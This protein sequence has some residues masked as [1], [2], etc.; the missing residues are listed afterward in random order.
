[1]K[2][3]GRKILFLIATVFA[4][5]PFSV[6]YAASGTPLGNQNG[7]AVLGFEIYNCTNYVES[8]GSEEDGLYACQQAYVEETIPPS[9]RI[10]NDGTIDKDKYIMVVLT[11][12]S[13]IDSYI[14]FLN[15][16]VS[17]NDEQLTAISLYDTAMYYEDTDYPYKK[18][19][20]NYVSRFTIDSANPEV[21]AAD[22]GLDPSVGTHKYITYNIG[23][24][25][26]DATLGLNQHQPIGY[27]FFK[28]NSDA[29]GSL[30]FSYG[31]QLTGASGASPAEYN[32]VSGTGKTVWL[33]Q[34]P[35]TISVTGSATSND[36]TL[37]TADVKYNATKFTY[38]S[39]TPWTPGVVTDGIYKIYVGN[40]TTDI[41]FKLVANNV[42]ATITSSTLTDTNAAIDIFEIEDV[43]ISTGMNTFRFTVTAADGT[44]QS[45]TFNVYKLS[46]DTSVNATNGITADGITLTK[47]ADGINYDGLTSF[48]DTDT[49]IYVNPTH[50][51]AFASSGAGSWTFTSSGSTINKRDV[52]VSAEN[53]KNEYLSIAENTCA[54]K[55]YTVNITRTNA[56]N[57]AN[58][59]DLRYGYNGAT[60]ATVSGF[61]GGTYTYNLGE[62]PNSTNSITI[63][64]VLDDQDNAQIL[65][66]TGD[67]TIAVGDNT[68]EVKT[69]AEDGSTKR[70][71]KLLVH[72]KSD[73]RTLTSLSVTSN[74]SGTLDPAFNKNFEG[75]YKYGY[76]P[77]V[78]KVKVRAEVNDT[79][80]AK[81]AIVDSTS[82][83]PAT[84]TST[85]NATEV[86]FN[87][88]ATTSVSVIVTSE[89]GGTRVYP[90]TLE[91]R[92]SN[93]N[94]LSNLK[95]EYEKNGT[96][97]A[98]LSP[99]FAASTRSYTVTVPADID[100]VT[101]T[102]TK[103]STY[104][105][106]RKIGDTTGTDLASATIDNLQ[107]GN[108]PIQVVVYS[109]AGVDNPYTIT[110]VRSKYNIATLESLEI[111]GGSFTST[112]NKN[113]TNYTYDGTIPYTTNSVILNGIK[114]NNYASVQVSVT[115]EKNNTQSQTISE[116]ANNSFTGIVNLPTGTNT[117][118]ILVTAHDNTTKTYTIRITRAKNND[119]TVSNLRVDGQIETPSY[120]D[121]THTYTVTVPFN[122]V[123]IAPGQVA[124]TPSDTNAT[125]TKG[126]SVSGLSTTSYKNFTFRVT[127]EDSTYTDYTVKIIKKQ[128]SEAKLTKV[129]A[130]VGST[131]YYCDVDPDTNT[132]TISVPVSTSSFTL[133]STISENA[134]VSPVNGTVIN[135]AS[136]E[137]SKELNITVTSEDGVNNTPYVITVERAK[138]SNNTLSDLQVD[139]V[140]VSGFSTSG[141]SF[142]DTEGGST[143][144]VTIK[145][146][147]DDTGKAQVSGAKVNGTDV[148]VSGTIE[149]G[150]F[151]FDAP[152]NYGTNTVVITV[153]AE[154]NQKQNYNLTITRQQ[155]ITATIGRLEFAEG[156][157]T[158]T[159]RTDWNKDGNT[160][161]LPTVDYDVTS[162]KLVAYPEDSTYGT[163]IVTKV[164]DEKNVT[165]HTNISNET[166]DAG[167]YV[168]TIPLTTGTNTITLVGYAHNPSV[169]KV[170]TLTIVRSKNS[171]NSVSN[172]KVKNIPVTDNGDDTYSVTLPN[173]VSS[174]TSADV[175]YTLPD[176]ATGAVSPAT[177]S[178]ST[179]TDNVVNL[180]VTSEG[181]TAKIYPIHIT[182]TKSNN[183]NLTRVSLKIVSDDPTYNGQDYY[184]NF[185]NTTSVACT[186]D[187]P[188]STTAYT[189]TKE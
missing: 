93:D 72:R 128:N 101:V 144:Q 16:T 155:N 116:G 105:T 81:V 125:V 149:S 14:R 42:G 145:A 33:N 83:Q 7:E 176:G 86:E 65:S 52:Y 57:N 107:F 173:S 70:T 6:I 73:D 20:K 141:N 46:D 34:N 180:T 161:T 80:K 56:S 109:E 142:S 157:D 148:T 4:F 177:L 165:Q 130:R 99:T 103:A 102:P 94:Y 183:A 88:P 159:E 53:C 18:Q 89:D 156:S 61:S 114:S 166:S 17:Y 60:P 25:D 153:E 115:D 113:T 71:Y 51:N 154:N 158:P 76:D 151:T 29:T 97:T 8:E 26:S 27:T 85:L 132:C 78:T 124:V 41:D 162:I 186:I 1:M 47:R 59:S 32:G 24:S 92:Q 171:D 67:F 187:V 120:D 147:V 21:S 160:Y 112:F 77:T 74:P 13:D 100:E 63:T 182:R 152:L 184:C 168:A 163:A 164:V 3:M 98:A 44:V 95:V 185:D 84:Y 45:Y 188:M 36:V 138:S 37:K 75:T 96:Q 129:T 140:T 139:G 49:T 123:A 111:A 118:G 79:G 133:T 126:A 178:L 137:S 69:I 167:K 108:N 15:S 122:T 9:Y 30:P 19:G 134:T 35:I 106:V 66:G 136:T 169:N 28:V 10:A 64:G 58:L 50:Q 135:M 40:L 179:Q 12:D 121:S 55:K 172:I 68:F 181:G 2:N 11:F 131:N 119:S 91:R 90:I 38:D 5:L 150:E 43:P 31:S 54:T 104:A 170:Y 87:V 189:S 110:I 127:A 48:A 62:V 175:T 117:I 146:V 23:T 82:G 143:S 174:I 39:T 22:M